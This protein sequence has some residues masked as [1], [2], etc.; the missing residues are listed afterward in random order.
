MSDVE[1]LV[2]GLGI[3]GISA[4]RAMSRDEAISWMAVDKGRSVGGRMA[5]R[6]LGGGAFDHGAQFFT[7]R[8]AEFQTLVNELLSKKVVREWCRGFNGGETAALTDG[9]PRYMSLLGMNRMAKYLVRDFTDDQIV[10]G[11]RIT[12][13][14][15]ESDHW[16]IVDQDGKKLSARHIVLTAP[17][18]QS[19][20]IAS[21]ALADPV[22]SEVRQSLASIH[23][24]PCV[25]IMGFF[26]VRTLPRLETPY[27]FNQGNISFLSDNGLKGVTDVTGAL[28]IHLS[29]DLSRVCFDRSEEEIKTVTL[30]SLRAEFPDFK[31]VLS[32]DFSIQKWRYATPKTVFNV[33]YIEIA[34]F[35]RAT[36]DVPRLF[37][38][39]EAFGGPRI[40]GAFLSGLAVGR[41][42]RELY[43]Q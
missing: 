24:D 31:F 11:R 37:F 10:F 9:F 20:E 7:V 5:T 33:P 17:V 6:R 23:Y 32:G 16:I 28:T 15:P 21:E 38:A 35:P 14:L 26:D 43:G 22:F 1:I 8:S 25:A 39:G 2:I 3:C 41:R 30:D 29:A 19:I 12:K 27:Q 36:N 13:I 42:I 18:P 40:E 4:V 34:K